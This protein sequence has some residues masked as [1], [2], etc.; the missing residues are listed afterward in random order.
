MANPQGYP[1]QGYSQEEYDQ[2]QSG[3]PVPAPSQAPARKKR[4]YAGQAFEFG[5]GANAGAPATQTPPPAAAY[6]AAQ[7]AAGYGYGAPV[8]QPAGYPDPQQQAAAAYGAPAAGYQPP[9]AYGA[10]PGG[11]PGMTQQFAQMGMAPQQQQPAQAPQQPA[12]VA[13][14]LNPLQ[15]V[16]ISVQGAPF[17]VSD[18]DLPPPP[19]ILPPN[20]SVTPSSNANCPPKYVRSTLNAIPSTNSLLKKSKLPFALVIQPYAT[21]HDAE[22][23]VPVQPDQVIARC[24]RCR[25][26]INP[27]ATF[28]DHSHRWRCNMCNLTNDVPQA[29]DWDNMKQQAI[30]RWQR[31]EL[32]YSVMEFVAPQEYMVRAPQPL[33]YLFLFDVSVASVQ[34]GLLATAARCVAESLDRIP[35]ADRRTRLAFM[36][37]DSSLH[38]FTIPRDD[39]GT[40]DSNMLVVSDLDEPFLPTPDGLL[41]SLADSRQNIETFLGKLQSMFQ[42]TQNGLSAMGSAMRAGH[43]MISHVGGKM[44]VLTA[45]LPNHGYGKLDMR[46]DKK[47]LGTSKESSLLQTANAFYKSFA[48]ECSKTQVS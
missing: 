8:Q 13:Q 19:I 14:R 12:P 26:Y 16:D 44:V 48:V 20:S 35:N 21:L 40:T 23:D 43:K 41:V 3:T 11:V 24:R 22:D 2:S 34:S 29:F 5:A 37:V 15:P 39:S 7:P 36:A 28:L 47:L 25:T 46:E 6:G 9:D 30:D 1:A 17:H 31:P 4:A 32:N 27:F 38:Y 45:S 18:L 33:V 10:A 42:S